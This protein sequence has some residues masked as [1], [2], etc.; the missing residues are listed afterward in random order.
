MALPFNSLKDRVEFRLRLF[1]VTDEFDMNSDREEKKKFLKRFEEYYNEDYDENLDYHHK[2]KCDILPYDEE[3]TF[4]QG[5]FNIIDSLEIVLKNYGEYEAILIRLYR[6]ICDK[7]E[8]MCSYV[9][10]HIKKTKLDLLQ[11]QTEIQKITGKYRNTYASKTNVDELIDLYKK[12]L[13]CIKINKRF[14]VDVLRSIDELINCKNLLWCWCTSLGGDPGCPMDKKT[15]F[16]V[17]TLNQDFTI[18]SL[19]Q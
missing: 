18:S 2:I 14:S 1:C 4:E 13:N 6:E 17:I 8:E 16:V 3:D 11:L 10:T 19:W 12:D 15:P 7:S 5:P 9:N